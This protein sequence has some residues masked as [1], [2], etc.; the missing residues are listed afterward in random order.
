MVIVAMCYSDF[1]YAA[2][3]SLISLYQQQQQQQKNNSYLCYAIERE[4]KEAQKKNLKF[5]L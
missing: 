3:E 4:V 2:L 1:F 5:M